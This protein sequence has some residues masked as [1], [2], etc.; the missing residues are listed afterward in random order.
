MSKGDTRLSERI[1]RA[2]RAL[3]AYLLDPLL[4]STHTIMKATLW[5]VFIGAYALSA[6]AFF[7]WV[8]YT[9]THVVSSAPSDVKER[10]HVL[11]LSIEMLILVPIPAVVGVV[12]Y[13]TLSQIADPLIPDLQPSEQQVMV[14]EHLLLGLLVTITGTTMLGELI[15]GDSKIENFIGG[16]LI[17][18]SLSIFLVTRHVGRRD[19][20]K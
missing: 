8:V 10:I 13:Q 12:S 14:A 7:H 18:A 19:A 15:L 1:M 2:N 3:D 5:I 11:L 17:V 16:A 6:T 4:L 9:Y 20:G